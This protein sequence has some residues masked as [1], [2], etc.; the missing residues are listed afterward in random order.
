MIPIK[1]HKKVNLLAQKLPSVPLVHA[2]NSAYHQPTIAKLMA[3]LNATIGSL[4][5]EF[6][7]KLTFSERVAEVR[8]SPKFFK[9]LRIE[10]KNYS[11]HHK[12]GDVLNRV[13][14]DIDLLFS[15]NLLDE[16]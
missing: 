16:I 7:P 15:T 1:H 5:G 13:S 12:N 11:H 14:M 9:R 4:P 8:V 3:F 6:P 10:M 2:A